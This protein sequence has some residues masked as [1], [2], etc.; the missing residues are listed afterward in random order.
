MTIEEYFGDWT[1]VI[2]LGEVD[3]IMKILISN[4][5]SLCPAIK[6]VFK[7]FTLCPLSKLKCIILGQDPYNNWLND[8]PVATGLAFANTPG[9]VEK[10]YSPSLDV[11]RRSVIDFS[12]PHNQI[13]FDISLEKWEE[14]GVMLLNSALSCM[15]GKTDSHTLLWRPFML[16]LLSNLSKST[17]GI[18][19]VLLGN[20]AWSFESYIEA[21]NNYILKERH[22]AYYA[23]CKKPMPSGIWR[24]I[25]NILT[26][27]YGQ[28][29]EWYKE[30]NY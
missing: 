23:R 28:G 8:R 12:V 19:Y 29:I 21:K 9:T 2:D 20:V 14:Q 6:D 18:V 30:S 4:K 26:D 24:E 10:D 1:R 13:T 25:N 15:K 7:A 27:L 11:L 3:R 22:P 5:E 17:N 16:S